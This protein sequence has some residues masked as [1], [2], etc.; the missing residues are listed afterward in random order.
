M[1]IDESVL[2][3]LRAQASKCRVPQEL[4]TVE[5]DECM[6]SFDSPWSPNGLYT[7]LNTWESFGRD[8]VE[9]DSARNGQLVYLFQQ[10]YKVTF[11]SLSLLCARVCNAHGHTARKYVYIL[12]LITLVSRHHIHLLI[13]H[14][15]CVC[16]CVT[17]CQTHSTNE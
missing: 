2:K 10:F 15:M 11:S 17:T 6:F 3:V 16:V 9:G 13:F 4:S 14:V 12:P 8:Y 5:K 1:T 7:N